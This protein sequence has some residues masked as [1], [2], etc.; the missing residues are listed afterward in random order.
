VKGQLKA[1]TSQVS[2]LKGA[3]TMLVENEVE[4]GEV[5][6]PLKKHSKSESKGLMVGN[7]V[8]VD[9]ENVVNAVQRSWR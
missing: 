3:L 5:V 9:L 8:K 6:R 1:L 2:I 7:H 4:K